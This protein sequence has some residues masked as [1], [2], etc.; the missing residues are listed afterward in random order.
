MH[1]E[2]YDALGFDREGIPTLD[3]LRELGLE[4]FSEAHD[5]DKEPAV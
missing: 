1:Q 5:H 3:T 2:Y 4:D